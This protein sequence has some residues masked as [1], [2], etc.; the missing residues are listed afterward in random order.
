MSFVVIN[1]DDF[2]ITGGV[3]EGI[4]LC[5]DAGVHLS[6]SA[7]MCIDGSQ[8]VVRQH[9]SRFNGGIGLH[10]QLT[11][12]T[13]ICT[14]R[15]VPSLVMADGRFPARR[16]GVSVR[17]TDV[18]REW[19]AQMRR[20]G[21][22][23]IAPDHIDTHH[24]VHAR[25]HGNGEILREYAALAAEFAL[26]AR[27]GPRHVAAALRACEVA[28][29]DVVVSFSEMQADFDALFSALKVEREVGPP[30][31]VIEICCH[32]GYYDSDLES[33]TLPH[34]GRLREKELAALVKG[35]L[36]ERLRRE[37]WTVIG[38]G[39]MKGLRRGRGS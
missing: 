27:S 9:A 29:P 22:F 36:V 7:M 24:D 2:G 38:Y 19:R 15:E 37:G 32:P 33:R 25:P 17:A 11:Q 6:T 39:D 10:L 3:A 31:L 16:P 30:D 4:V 1:A 35:G 21:E 13:P 18:A 34:Y 5:A 8:A 20:L 14:A 28:C 12:G 23:G 26:P